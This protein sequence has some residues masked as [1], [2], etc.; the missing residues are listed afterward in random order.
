VDFSFLRASKSI[1]AT[2][3]I[4]LLTGLVF[5]SI[6]T[7]QNAGGQQPAGQAGQTKNW[8]DVAEYDLYNKANST[9]DPKAKLQLLNTW[10]D[11]YPQS[12]YA[13]LRS[14]LF[15]AT[16]GQLAASDPSQR[17]ALVTKCEEILK[18]DPKNFTAAYY[19]ALNGPIV[20]GT[21][22]P[23]DL[24][25]QVETAAHSVADQADTM[26]SADKKKPSMT[27]A[28]WTEAKNQVVAL[29]HNALAWAA[30]SKKDA[31]TAEN[32]YKASLQANPNQANVSAA[33]G[34]MLMEQ[35]KYQDAL[36]QYA[37]AASY[38][39]PGSLPAGARTQLMEY[40]KKVYGQFHGSPDGADQVLA[41]AK[42][43]AVPPPDFKIE[44]QGDIEAA[45]AKATNDR[46]ASDPAFKLWY[47]IETNLKG[48]QGDQ[49]F[50]SSVK[51]VEMPAGAEG[52]KSFSGTVISV[53]PSKVVLGVE[54]PTKPDATL[55]FA[56]P[57]PAAALDKI[58]VG[59]KL[60][61]SG[62]GDSFTK[63]P[64]ML[65]L[66]DP[67]VPGVPTTA[68]PAKKPAGTRRRPPR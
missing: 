64:Y 42:T 44:G 6:A 40:F 25:S 14:Q 16:L 53:D 23:A 11:K 62:A 17:Q 34:K 46:M 59:E 35:K 51:D 12:D 56:H 21:N 26:F 22:P 54:D 30:T 57:L 19:L 45:K 66:K 49:F 39:G 32:E 41:Q 28:Q 15:I 67:S 1:V 58:K 38:D 61:F 4:A 50:N 20:G 2:S 55:V 29:G 36:F 18:A 65:T 7:A 60:E 8:K 63:D 31:A 52:V 5:V 13:D 3:A 68:A 48:D 9:A 43:N 10:Q 47:T 37:R 24:I 27:D 33:Y